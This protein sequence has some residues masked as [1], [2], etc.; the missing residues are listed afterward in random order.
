MVILIFKSFPIKKETIEKIIS[1]S[2]IH[3]NKLL[4]YKIQHG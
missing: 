4:K 3:N 2:T 1:K